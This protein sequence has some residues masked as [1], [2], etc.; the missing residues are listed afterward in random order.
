MNWAHK[1]D[2]C[3]KQKPIEFY[4]FYEIKKMQKFNSEYVNYAG[5]YESVHRDI[6]QEK[7]L[8]VWKN[9]L[10]SFHYVKLRWTHL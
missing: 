8:S 5:L 6:L 3:T 1:K 7:E 10:S 9:L 2:S 4:L